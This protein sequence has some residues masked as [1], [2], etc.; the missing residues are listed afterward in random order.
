M[1][2]LYPGDWIHSAQ[3]AAI[4]LATAYASHAHLASPRKPLVLCADPFA[5]L[6]AM[7]RSAAESLGDVAIDGAMPLWHSVN[8]V[9]DRHSHA[10]S[11]ARAR[12]LTCGAGPATPMTAPPYPNGWVTFEVPG[13][14]ASIEIRTWPRGVRVGGRFESPGCLPQ[15]WYGRPVSTPSPI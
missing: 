14:V 11:H 13:S 1:R 2:P 8:S 12:M 9:P 10:T 3:Q 6:W 5:P 4:A 7:D 15:A